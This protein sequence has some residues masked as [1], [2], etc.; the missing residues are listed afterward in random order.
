MAEMMVGFLS[1]ILMHIN[2]TID[3]ESGSGKSW[4][5]R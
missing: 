3:R 1:W 5:N 2:S 4:P